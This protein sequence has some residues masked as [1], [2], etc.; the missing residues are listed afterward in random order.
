MRN[1]KLFIKI[2][3][4]IAAILTMAAQIILACMS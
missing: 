4:I 1:P 3:R 2:L